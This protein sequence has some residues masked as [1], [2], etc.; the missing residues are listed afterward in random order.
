MMFC[1]LGVFARGW[2]DGGQSE[3]KRGKNT[4]CEGLEVEF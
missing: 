3:L 2:G 4:L 1:A